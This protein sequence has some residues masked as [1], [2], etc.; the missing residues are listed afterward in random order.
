M[1]VLLV[2][3]EPY[4]AEAIRDGLRLEAIAADIAGDGDTA[5]E[6]P[7]QPPSD[8]PERVAPSA[9][10]GDLL[11][12]VK[13]Q[14]AALQVPAAAR[15]N[16]TAGGDPAGA[17]LAVG[18]GLRGRV[19]DELAA[20]QRSP[21]RLDRLSDHLVGKAGHRA[22][23][24]RQREQAARRR[25]PAWPPRRAPTAAPPRPTGSPP[26][27]PAP[28]SPGESDVSPSAQLQ[29]RCCD[30]REDPSK[31]VRHRAGEHLPTPHS[32]IDGTYETPTMRPSL[33]IT[34]A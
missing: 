24:C 15:T 2:E 5:L 22:S 20:L 10:Q 6:L 4:M 18:A 19:G 26:R 11:A 13:R 3:D 17:L 27:R 32:C 14:A 12:L 29:D 33:E 9:T 23:L 21:E 34:L 1:R 8:H 16:A 31:G 28:T 30:H 7:A 25:K